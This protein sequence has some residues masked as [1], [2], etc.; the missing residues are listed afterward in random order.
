MGKVYS[1]ENSGTNFKTGY[2]LLNLYERKLK[3]IILYLGSRSVLQQGV[4]PLP[5][6][7]LRLS[8]Q[9]LTLDPENWS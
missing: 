2:F 3:L 7:S 1:E 8:C 9:N 6:D 5:V 4:D